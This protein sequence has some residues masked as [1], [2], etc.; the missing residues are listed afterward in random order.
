MQGIFD[1]GANVLPVTATAPASKTSTVTGTTIDCQGFSALMYVI[2]VGTATTL[3]GSDYF[4]F[5]D[6]TG[7]AANGSDKVAIS[8]TAYQYATIGGNGLG[9]SSAWASPYYIGNG[10]N[11]ASTSYGIGIS[12]FDSYNTTVGS[13]RYHT[14]LLTATG[15]PSA[16]LGVTALLGTATHAPV[17]GPATV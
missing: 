8:T 16:I 10:N 17:L 15:S 9:N 1:L 14:Y 7:A 13:N 11:S 6:N 2:S 5:T 4:T 3:D 12:L